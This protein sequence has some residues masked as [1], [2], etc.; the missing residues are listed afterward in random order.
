MQSQQ[1][2]PY[3]EN[4]FKPCNLIG[5]EPYVDGMSTQHLVYTKNFQ[6]ASFLSWKHSLDFLY[7]HQKRLL[8][9]YFTEVQHRAVISPRQEEDCLLSEGFR[10][11]D[12]RLSRGLSNN[13]NRWQFRIKFGAQNN[14]LPSKIWRDWYWFKGKPGKSFSNQCFHEEEE[15][16]AVVRVIECCVA[17]K[18]I[19]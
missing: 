17:A 3:M 18:I 2:M 4:P 9:T 14:S 8:H 13:I 11:R 1:D 6:C 19:P 12:C 10:P 7:Y 16:Y 5:W 15:E